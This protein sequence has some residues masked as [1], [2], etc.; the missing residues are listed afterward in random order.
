MIRLLLAVLLTA[1]AVLI[2]T[3]DAHA[4]SCSELWYQ[5][6]SIFKAAG[7][8]F[9]TARGIRT[10]GNAGCQYDDEAEVPLSQRQR[11]IV[12]NLRAEERDRGCPR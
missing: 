4:Q 9:K 7:Y 2:A 8:C 10:F 1:A 12:A 5:R 6:N 11:Q 3:T